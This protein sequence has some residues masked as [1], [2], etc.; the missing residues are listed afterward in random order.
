MAD[1]RLMDYNKKSPVVAATAHD[2]T[3]NK[4]VIFSNTDDSG[5]QNKIQV[6]LLF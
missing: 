2:C 3:K 4:T 5:T 1:A 6:K